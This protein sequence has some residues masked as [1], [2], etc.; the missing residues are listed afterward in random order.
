M[1][2]L[3]IGMGLVAISPQLHQ[4]LHPDAES[5]THQCVAVQLNKGPLMLGL[6]VVFAPAPVSISVEL[7]SFEE[8]HYLPTADHRLC[9]SRGP[10]CFSRA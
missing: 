5:G 10:P 7:P 1:L 3:W 2:A 4:W 9:S 8:F 6:P